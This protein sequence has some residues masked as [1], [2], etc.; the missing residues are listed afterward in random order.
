MKFTQIRHGS[1]IIEY[2]NKKFLV[3]P[4]LANQGTAFAMPK[5]RL[6][7][8]NPLVSLP[9]DKS[10][11]NDVDA[12][13][14]THMHFDHFD[15]SAM[16]LLPKTLPV[17]CHTNDVK[18]IIKAGFINVEGILDTININN[19]IS[20]KAIHGGKHGAGLT[21][22]LM[23]R[24]TGYV[25]K[26]ISTEKTEQT[27]YLIGDSIWCETVKS[28][29]EAHKPR[30]IIAFAGEAR[31]PFGKPITMSINDINS[32]A[33]F[34][35]DS[36][37]VINHMDAWNHCYLTRDNLKKFIETKPYK[38]RIIIPTDGETMMI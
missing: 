25:L 20:I 37:I 31:L 35:E 3:D 38:E 5:G 8:K 6:D 17:Y 11:I 12:L 34:D 2:K 36:F 13:I 10:F 15:H 14:I 21:G 23:G 26:D 16:K 1:H 30:V 27:V 9:F 22:I 19:D 33:L 32:M 28:A 29:I 18:K 7:N 4:V 24:T